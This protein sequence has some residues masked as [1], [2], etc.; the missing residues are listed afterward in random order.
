MDDASYRQYSEESSDWLKTARTDLLLHLIAK[1]RLTDKPLALLEVGAGV[2]QNLPALAGLGEVDAVEINPYGRAA[3]NKL[4]VVRSLFSDPVPFVLERRYD[5]ICALDVIEHI[6]DA[7]TAVKWLS[8]HLSP[9]GIMV[10]TV[11]AYQWL[12]SEHDRV[13][14]HHRRYTKTRLMNEVPADMTIETAA[15]FTHLLFPVAVISRLAWMARRRVMGG[16]TS[17][18]QRS[19]QSGLI[20]RILR[21]VMSLEIGLIK[22]GYK[23]TWGLS[24]YCVARKQ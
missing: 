7:K 1:Y 8:E 19:P 14:G 24:A 23:P 11:P 20:A 9:G 3:I 16:R 12:F 2:G 15:Y 4:G 22:M 21:N 13:L 18:K 5:V 6:E 17:E 10:L